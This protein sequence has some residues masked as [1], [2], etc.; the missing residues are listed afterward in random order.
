MRPNRANGRLHCPSGLLLR[1]G[2]VKPL[3]EHTFRRASGQL[4]KLVGSSGGNND[5]VA[6]R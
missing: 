5:V 1:A 6:L 3:R 4:I 2:H